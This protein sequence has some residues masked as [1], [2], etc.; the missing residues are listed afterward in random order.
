MRVILPPRG[1]I[2]F[3]NNYKKKA[4]KSD[5]AMDIAQILLTAGSF[6]VVVILALSFIGG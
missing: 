4:S 2:S 6:V 3:T 5:T 1:K